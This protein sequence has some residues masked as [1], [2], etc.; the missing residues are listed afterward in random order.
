MQAANFMYLAVLKKAQGG[1]GG[2]SVKFDEFTSTI[3]LDLYRL[4]YYTLVSAQ[5]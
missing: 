5:R 2:E 1:V 4:F 3:L